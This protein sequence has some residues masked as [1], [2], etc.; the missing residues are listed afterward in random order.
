MTRNPI[1]ANGWYQGAWSDEVGRELLQRWIVNRPVC[2]YRCLDGTVTAIEDRCPHRRFPLSQG[3]LD[4]DVVQCGYHGYR[5][6]AGGV[7]VGVAEQ[8]DTP[9]ATVHRFPVVERYGIV[10]IWPGDAEAADPDLIPDLSW[11]VDDGWSHVQGMVPLAAR[12]VLLAENL[13]DLTHETFLHAGS[14]GNA[15]VAATPIDVTSEGNR[16]SF[17]R[18]MVG[19]DAPPFYADSLGVSVIDRW[20]D[21][22]FHAPGVFVLNIRIAPT[23]VPEPEGFHLKVFYGLTPE[24]DTTTHDFFALGRD[25]R[26]ED[27]ELSSSYLTQQLAVMQEDVDALE[28]QERMV[29]SETV[30]M[31]ESSI[32]SDV[33][34]IRG[35]RLLERL[36]R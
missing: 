6:D 21:G 8:P 18:H 25:F 32:R 1:V 34:G 16:V 20:Q 31:R 23:G 27:E 15:A 5:I 9:K 29:A 7:C 22:D 19:V 26:V 24:T 13:L 2:F 33:A 3:T 28:I 4:G 10:W 14:I 30:P 11:L 36:A 12:Q 35:R 17:L